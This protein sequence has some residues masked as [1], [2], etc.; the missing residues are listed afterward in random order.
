[1][2]A[3]LLTDKFDK[4]GPCGWRSQWHYSG[5]LT[6]LSHFCHRTEYKTFD[7]IWKRCDSPY[8]FMDIM[9]AE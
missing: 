8:I 7:Y 4:R 9:A 5:Y 3:P 6:T 2:A 1:M